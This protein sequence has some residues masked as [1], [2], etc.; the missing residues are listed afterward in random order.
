MHANWGDIRIFLAI[1]RAGSLGRAARSCG[2]TQPTMGRRL[3]ALEA[4]IGQT[5]FQRT[6]HGFVLTD[7]GSAMLP[8]AE[9]MEEEFL[10]LER[11]LAGSDRRLQGGLRVTSSD[12]FGVHVLTP[13]FARFAEVHPDV[14]IELVTDSRLYSL[15]RRETDLAFRITRFEEVDVIQRQLMR[16]RYAAY[17]RR[18]ADA[19]PR[20]ITMD[21]AFSHL[22]DAIWLR[23]RLPDAPVAFRTNDRQAQA[24]ACAEGIGIA[25]LPV[26]LG[27]RQPHIER[28]DLGAIAPARDVWMGYHRDLRRLPRLRALVDFTV[29]TLASEAHKLGDQ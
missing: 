20:L 29:E 27:D 11:T 4:A 18:G 10:S 22:P 25:V 15:S 8:P 13:V 24:H 21:A 28:L 6:A 5:L 7:E 26:A 1:A 9:R 14:T 12:W 3:K 2:L 19:A 23:A 17:R 16:I